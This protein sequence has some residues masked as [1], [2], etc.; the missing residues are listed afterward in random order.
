MS[1]HCRRRILRTVP[2]TSAPTQRVPADPPAAAVRTRPA[3]RS[4][5]RRAVAVLALP[6]V[7]LL[8][9]TGCGGSSKPAVCGKRDAVKTSVDN[10]TKLNPVTDGL[11]AVQTQLSAVQQSVKDLASAAGDQYKPQV[12]ALQTSLKTLQSQ[13][14]ALG[15]NPSVPALT[16]VA[17]AAQQVA[18]D[19]KALTDAIGSACN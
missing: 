11:G 7:V 8:V 9:A 17:P 18:T 12:T 10:L 19:F 13:I 2:D 3:V 14:T 4:D 15:S 5:A 6:I 16:A 1:R